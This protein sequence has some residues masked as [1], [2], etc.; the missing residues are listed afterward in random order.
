[1][2]RMA[3]SSWIS[4]SRTVRKYILLLKPPVYGILLWKPKQTK[5]SL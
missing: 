3:P 5:R 1:L 4:A 2:T